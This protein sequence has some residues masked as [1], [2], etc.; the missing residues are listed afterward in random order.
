M[1]NNEMKKNQ[2]SAHLS[3]FFRRG[4]TQRKNLNQEFSSQ[5]ANFHSNILIERKWKNKKNF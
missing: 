2:M 4:Y 5:E 3:P 1:M